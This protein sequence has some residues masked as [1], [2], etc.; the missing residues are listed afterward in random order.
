MCFQFFVS[1][2]NNLHKNTGTLGSNIS[3]LE[4]ETLKSTH[5]A[6]DSFSV[7]LNLSLRL[8]VDTQCL[9]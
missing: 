2:K 3:L 7:S 8:L 9:T 5:S 6:Q 4:A 1:A